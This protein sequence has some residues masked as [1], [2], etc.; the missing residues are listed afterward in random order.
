MNNE[1]F[2][3]YAVILSDDSI[4]ISALLLFFV[5]YMKIGNF[6]MPI[7]VTTHT[8]LD[9]TTS[10]KHKLNHVVLSYIIGNAHIYLTVND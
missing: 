1:S 10:H 2:F 9:Y 4:A 7:Y 8:D 3:T 5:I 6:L